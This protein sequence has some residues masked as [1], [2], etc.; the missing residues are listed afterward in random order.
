M[1]FATN[2]GCFLPAA[3]YAP[4]GAWTF[5]GAT[6]LSGTTAL[7]SPTLTTP[8]ITTPTITSAAITGTTTF[9]SAKTVSAASAS[10]V[11]LND[12]AMTVSIGASDLGGSLYAVRG[13]VIIS[14]ALSEAFVAGVRAG[15]TVSSTITTTSAT[16]I[17]ALFAKLDVSAATL[18]SGQVSVAWFDWGATATTPASSECNVIRVQ[19]TTAAVINALIYGYGKA[20][21]FMDVS[22]NSAGW[23]TGTTASTAAGALKVLVNGTTAY[24]Q[25]FSGVA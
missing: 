21:Y 20:T 15:C 24:I 6:T 17:T 2:G 22:D 12:N 3:D 23:V 25:L 5:T 9:T 19:N 7:T 4:S 10:A 1:G 18:T 16:R 8:T 14:S 11:V 13:N